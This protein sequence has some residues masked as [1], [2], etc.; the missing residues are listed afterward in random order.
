MPRTGQES[1]FLVSKVADLE[2]TLPTQR[3][4]TTQTRTLMTTTL[5]PS[6]NREVLRA[7][8]RPAPRPLLVAFLLPHKQTPRA[9]AAPAT[10][11]S[12]LF[13]A[14]MQS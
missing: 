4:R 2:A 14:K 11:P 6:L 7:S 8:Q 12:L 3:I 5:N 13:L 1:S 9:P 10:P